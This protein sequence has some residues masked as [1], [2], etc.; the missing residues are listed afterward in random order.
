MRL[1][2]PLIS[3][4]KMNFTIY[5]K[6]VVTEVYNNREAHNEV[7]AM[8]ARGER[9]AMFFALDKYGY[10]TVRIE[11]RTTQ[12]FTYQL[13]Q[14]GLNW[15]LGYL[16]NGTTED[17]DVDPNNPTKT[18]ETTDDGF[19]KNMLMA[20]VKANIG[21]FQT[22]PAFLDRPG[23]LT[24]TATFKHGAIQFFT[25]RDAEIEEFMQEH[26]LIG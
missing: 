8:M 24:T 19:R 16:M 15:I 12:R 14:Q 17:C 20:F 7:R 18:N 9:M 4:D 2:Y 26:K 21:N 23:R 10:E 13:N 11:S 6:P 22:R 3:N 1:V 5:V 25:E